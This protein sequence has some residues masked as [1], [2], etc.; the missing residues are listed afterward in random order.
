MSTERVHGLKRVKDQLTRCIACTECYGRGPHVPYADGGDVVPD[1]V[2]PILD[3]FKF[4]TYSA[5]S[6]QILARQVAYEHLTPDESVARAFY[7]CTTCGICGTICPRP[8]VDTVRAMREEIQAN[9]RELYPA[10]MSKPEENI[11]S[12][13]NF[14]GSPPEARNRWSAKLDVSPRAE[15]LYFAGC[16]ASYRQPETAQA[17]VRVL[18]AA[19]QEVAL[20]GAEEWC[21]GQPAGWAGNWGLEEEMAR[22]NVER[23]RAA[24]SRLVVFSCAEC[25]RAFKS[26]YP[27]IVGKL[28]FETAHVVEVYD[29]LLREKKL[30]LTRK[31]KEAVTYHDPCYL[32]RQHLGRHQDL[33]EQPRSVIQGVPGIQFREMALH[34]RFAYCCGGGGGVTSQVCPEESAW[35]AQKR[36]RQAAAVAQV[37]V[38][39]CP[40]CQEQLLQG[41]RESGV[42]VGVRDISALLAEATG[43]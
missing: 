43:L 9:Y 10:A 21:C 20:L 23:I 34:H 4:V 1:W 11:R 32:I 15:I 31:V 12:R 14:F 36:I 27:R 42:A 2:C 13:H 6:Q 25:Y 3:R 29:R 40:R 39:A 5:R 30:S 8:L 16:Y 38:T 37:V 41:A 19:G 35:F 7:A 33:Y 22:H 17:V 18:R 24:G 28:P 26:D